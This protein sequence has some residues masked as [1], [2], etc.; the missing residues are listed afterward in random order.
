MR[1]T[2]RARRPQLEQ[3]QP[4]DVVKVVQV[5]ENNQLLMATRLHYFPGNRATQLQLA[6]TSIFSGR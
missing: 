4:R 1:S 6:A 5:E 2:L 3:N